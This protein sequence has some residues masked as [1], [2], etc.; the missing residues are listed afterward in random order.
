MKL[1]TADFEFEGTQEDFWEVVHPCFLERELNDIETIEHY[2]QAYFQWNPG[3]TESN[4]TLQE[5]LEYWREST[6]TPE[7]EAEPKPEAPEQ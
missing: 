3:K 1:K 2:A 6:A 7:Q 5:Y 4:T